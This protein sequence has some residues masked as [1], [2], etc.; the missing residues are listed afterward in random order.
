M[1][2]NSEAHV[3]TDTMDQRPDSNAETVGSCETLYIPSCGVLC[4]VFWWVGR[5]NDNAGEEK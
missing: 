2:L 4:D 1:K 5:K 3:M